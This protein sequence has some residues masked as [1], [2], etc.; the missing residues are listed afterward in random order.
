MV[1][2]FSYN[3]VYILLTR[4]EHTPHTTAQS[5]IYGS[6][7]LQKFPVSVEKTAIDLI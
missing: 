5:F 4:G 6:S 1:N 3:H 2:S 7:N